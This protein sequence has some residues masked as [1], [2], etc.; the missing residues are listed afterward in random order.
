MQKSFHVRVE[1]RELAVIEVSIVMQEVEPVVCLIRFFGG[2]GHLRKE[3][4]FRLCILCLA[5][6]CTNTG[7]RAIY[8]LRHH[9]LLIRRV[10]CEVLE[11]PHNTTGKVIRK[12]FNLRRILLLLTH[13]WFEWALLWLVSS[14]LIALHKF[15]VVHTPTQNLKPK[16]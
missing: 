11:E 4:G 15:L 10:L 16:T 1:R 2:D 12:F 13:Q 14:K 3:I 9:I 8:L 6:I 5:D 7:S